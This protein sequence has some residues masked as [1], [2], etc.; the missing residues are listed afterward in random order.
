V[1]CF[2]KPDII[3]YGYGS[4]AASSA[5]ATG[6]VQPHRRR[7]ERPAAYADSRQLTSR[8][9]AVAG[10]TLG[11]RLVQG[12]AWVRLLVGVENDLSAPDESGASALN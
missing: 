9:S 8:V 3:G 10:S 5:T 2:E 1:Y 6:A 12:A 4:G 7:L 11:N